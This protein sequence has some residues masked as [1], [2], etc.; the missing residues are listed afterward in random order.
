[1]NYSVIPL[2]TFMVGFKTVRHVEFFQERGG[3]KY[4][5]LDV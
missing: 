3:D 5:S 4:L 2:Q 1:M